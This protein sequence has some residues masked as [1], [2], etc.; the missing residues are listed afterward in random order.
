M[1]SAVV[2]LGFLK[3]ISALDGGDDTVEV[4]QPGVLI[5]PPI[6][7]IDEWTAIATRQQAELALQCGEDS[8]ER[9]PT[10]HVSQPALWQSLQR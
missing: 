5:L 10:H 6:L 9:T 8:R 7:G 2:P 4:R 3:R 1:P